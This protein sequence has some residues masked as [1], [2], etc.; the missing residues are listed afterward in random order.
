MQTRAFLLGGSPEAPRVLRRTIFCAVL[1]S[2]ICTL[3]ERTP[4]FHCR[5]KWLTVHF[6]CFMHKTCYNTPWIYDVNST[7]IRIFICFFF[8]KKMDGG[9]I[10]GFG[11]ATKMGNQRSVCDWTIDKI[12]IKI[13]KLE[14]KFLYFKT[15][16][17]FF[18]IAKITRI[19]LSQERIKK[20]EQKY[21]KTTSLF[22]STICLRPTAM[23]AR[24]CFFFFFWQNSE[25]NYLNYFNIL[26]IW[27]LIIWLVDS[28]GNRNRKNNNY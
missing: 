23:T 6:A 17:N 15:K 26:L 14:L 7:V 21:L 27:I 18:L 12:Q 1:P 4:L 24:K 10:K 8:D 22:K 13:V 2:W 25:L 5:F 20:N 11:K 3:M 9:C 19:T 16:Q 28:N